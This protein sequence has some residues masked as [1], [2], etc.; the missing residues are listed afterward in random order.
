VWKTKNRHLLWKAVF[1]EMISGFN[2][3]AN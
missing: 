1:N 2:T 3:I